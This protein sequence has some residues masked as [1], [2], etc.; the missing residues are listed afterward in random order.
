MSGW[1]IW[2]SFVATS[3][4]VTRVNVEQP[5]RSDRT[6]APVSKRTYDQVSRDGYDAQANRIQMISIASSVEL[7]LGG[8]NQQQAPRVKQEN[9]VLPTTSRQAKMWTNEPTPILAERTQ[10]RRQP[11]GPIDPHPSPL[12]LS[13]LNVNFDLNQSQD[14]TY[15]RDGIG[16]NRVEPAYR[17]GKVAARK[18]EV[19]NESMNIDK[20]IESLKAYLAG[21]NPNAA[22]D[23]VLISQVKSFLSSMALNIY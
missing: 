22:M 18:P 21:K 16:E 19:F 9:K 2:K 4:T 15:Y 1:F 23:Q 6:S 7:P 3:D 17:G 8:E 13:Q 12:N 11:V 5:A 14:Q 10:K 20:W